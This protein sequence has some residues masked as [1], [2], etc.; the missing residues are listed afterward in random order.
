MLPTVMHRF[1]ASAV[2]LAMLLTM[3]ACDLGGSDAQGLTGRWQGEVVSG[4][5]ASATR[6]SITLQLSDTGQTVTGTGTVASAEGDQ[7]FAVT[8][9]SFINTAV[10]LPLTFANDPIPGSLSGALTNRDPGRI[11]GSFS[12]PSDTDG[13]VQIELVSR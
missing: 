11:T 13:Q 5:G 2:A 3:T 1:L 8:R 10:E 4:T 9:G 12:G 6:Y 7:P